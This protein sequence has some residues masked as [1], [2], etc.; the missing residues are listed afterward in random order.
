MNDD[1]TMQV[2][3]TI[4]APADRV[5]AVLADPTQHTVIDGSGLLRGSES[6]AISGI[7]QVFV[8]DMYRDDLGAYRVLNTVTA[9]E[10]DRRIGW[11]P[12]LDPDCA[13]AEQLR[14][15]ITTGGHTYVYDLS[16]RGDATEVTQTYDWSGV[17][18]PNFEAYCPFVT[19]DDLAATL[20]RLADAVHS[21]ARS[22]VDQSSS[23]DKL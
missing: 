22:A 23:A 21:T 12:N 16:A 4:Q 20:D 8:V 14:G 18:D 7:G 17:R 1:K 9:F 6:D 19:H 3:R 11:A 2:T 15:K 5:F 13:L 10:P